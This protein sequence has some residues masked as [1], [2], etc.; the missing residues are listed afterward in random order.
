M[1]LAGARTVNLQLKQQHQRRDKEEEMEG[2]VQNWRTKIH[3][4]GGWT[5]PVLRRLGGG[6]SRATFFFSKPSDV[7]YSIFN[8]ERSSQ[9][10]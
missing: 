1:S 9:L 7:Q 6:E 2:G 5:L 10:Q 3:R 4:R 8:V